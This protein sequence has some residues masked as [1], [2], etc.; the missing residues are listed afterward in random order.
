[1][2]MIKVNQVE[3]GF[4]VIFDKEWG[5]TV[6]L[7]GSMENSYSMLQMLSGMLLPDMSDQRNG[8][9]VAIHKLPRT[10]GYRGM[11]LEQLKKG[12]DRLNPGVA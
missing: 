5:R 3:K 7:S 4:K 10:V 6:L 12:L 9:N 2:Y 1:M 11:M 8:G